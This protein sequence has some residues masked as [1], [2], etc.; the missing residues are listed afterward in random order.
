M[1]LLL[2]CLVAAAALRAADAS[3]AHNTF[4]QYCFGCHS[5]AAMGGVSLEKLLASASVGD[6]FA[7]WQKVIGVLEQKRM[8]PPKMPSPSDAQRQAAAEWIR[9]EL[10]SYAAKHA[11]DPGRVTVRR[12]TSA[13]YAYTIRDLTG[14]DFQLDGSFATDAVGGEGFTN[15]GDVQ[16]VH[17]SS[18]ERFLEAAKQ[19]ANHA[20]IGAGPL[21]FFE[22]PGKT[23][24]ELSAIKRIQD[25]YTANGFR[26][27][28]AEGAMPYGLDRYS[29]AFYAAWR[30]KHRAALGRPDATIASVAA[31]EKV[32]PRFL[33]HILTVVEQPS[34]THPLSEVIAQWRALPAPPTA[35]ETAVRAACDRMKDFV[36]DWPRYVF[37]AGELA[38]GGQ[39]D[40]R[41]LVLSESLLKPVTRYKFRFSLRNG[42]SRTSKAYLTVVALNPIAK[43]NP[44]VRWRNAVVRTRTAERT[45][46]P[47]QPLRPDFTTETG[48]TFELDVQAPD[49]ARAIELTI[50]AEIPAGGDAVL[51]CTVSDRAD[52][53]KGRPVWALLGDPDSAGFRAWKAGVLD[54]AS[55]LPQNS[56]SEPAPADRDEIPQPFDNTYNQ[57]ERDHFHAK[58]K[59]FRNDRFIV[60]KMLDD[61]TRLKL[62]RAWA[63]LLTSFDY[64]DLFIQFVE[65]KFGNTQ[66]VERKRYIETL[67]AEHKTALAL[68]HMGER[69]HMDDLLKFAERAWR[70]PLHEAEKLALRNFYTT[71]RQVHKQDHTGAIRAV[72]TRVLV[73]PAFLYRSEPAKLAGVRPLSDWEMASRLSYFLWSSMP[74][75]ELRRAAV[76][77]ELS[78]RDELGKQVK[79]ML[80]DAKARR[81]ATEFFGQWLGFYLFDQHTGVDTKR[82]PEFTG[83]V[84]AAMYNEAISFFEHIVRQDRPV[85]D[86]FFADYTFLDKTLAKYYGIP[87]ELGSQPQRIDGAQTFGR[88]GVLRMGAVLTATS[89][90][91]RTSPVKRGDWMLRR[92]LGTPTPPPPADAGSIPA[93]EKAFGGLSLREKM[94]VHKRNA[95]CAGCHTRIDPLGFPFEKYDSIGRLRTHYADGKAV[96]DSAM[97]SD[98]QTIEGIDG[99]L[100]YLRSADKQV[101]QTMS[102]KLL[103]YALGRTVSASDASLVETLVTAGS[104]APLSKLISEIVLSKQFRYRRDEEVK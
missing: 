64:H 92:V 101:M 70:R 9:A 91:L 57:P 56:Q 85:R 24:L 40:E 49:N 100:K 3:I 58:L 102:Y 71:A 81:F 61:V 52:V 22:D 19:V 99:L 55:K 12:L 23:G 46:G 88:G 7:A 72:L 33:Q 39:G 95:T 35:E 30:Y 26:S 2:A 36:V 67:R 17:D 66:S 28:A 48:S 37:A 53:S 16:F 50:D 74:D 75:D 104:E 63:D 96:D 41:A 1:K 62:D 18:I 60:E 4:K 44:P 14:L 73:A 5:R 65:K 93:D 77:G 15:F 78:K 82:F 34:A 59:Y 11:G 45:F 89:A 32:S 98:K 103:G 68:V 83:E 8:P 84:K 80:A 25:I 54:F 21:S 27:V 20:V 43:D 76:A 38:K 87:K 97:T 10:K 69:R 86:I 13:E 29:R 90:P 6:N 79:R 51:R 42:D 31:A 94:E 47:P